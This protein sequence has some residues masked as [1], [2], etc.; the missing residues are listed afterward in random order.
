MA[1]KERAAYW[2]IIVVLVFWA[3]IEREQTERYR[4]A[5]AYIRADNKAWRDRALGLDQNYIDFI[6]TRSGKAR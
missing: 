2:G 4:Y 6:E 5:D 1:I 3:A